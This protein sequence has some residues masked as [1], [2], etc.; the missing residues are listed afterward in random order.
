MQ[1]S[2]ARSVQILKR[3]AGINHASILKV[4]TFLVD[5]LAVG[6]DDGLGHLGADFDNATIVLDG[7]VMIDGCIGI[8]LGISEALLLEFDNAFHQRMRQLEVYLLNIILCH[9]YLLFCL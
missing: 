2:L 7:I 8:V 3:L 6:F 1:T 4:R 5:T 9:N